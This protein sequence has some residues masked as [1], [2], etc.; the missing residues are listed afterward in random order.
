MGRFTVVKI[1]ISGRCEIKSGE[2]VAIRDGS[3]LFPISKLYLDNECLWW[4]EW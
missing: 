3:L 2:D 1:Q 4:F